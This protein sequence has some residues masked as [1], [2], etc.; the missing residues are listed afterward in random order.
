MM[1]SLCEPQLYDTGYKGSHSCTYN[2][3]YSYK[4]TIVQQCSYTI[5][6]SSSESDVRIFFKQCVFSHR[7]NIY[8]VYLL[9]FN[10]KLNLQTYNRTSSH[11]VNV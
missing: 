2:I 8:F 7:Q 4:I 6:T 9:N 1:L 3:R 11:N 5:R 10:I